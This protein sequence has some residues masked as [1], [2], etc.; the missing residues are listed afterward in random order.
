MKPSWPSYQMW[1]DL[2]EGV[3]DEEHEKLPYLAR[4]IFCG[5]T[6]SAHFKVELQWKR[7]SNPIET[8]RKYDDWVCG[9]PLLKSPRDWRKFG[10]K[11]PVFIE[12][13]SLSALKPLRCRAAPA[14]WTLRWAPEYLYNYTTI[15][16]KVCGPARYGKGISSTDLSLKMQ[17]HR[18]ADE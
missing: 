4:L 6:T 11:I 9:Q 12:I 5:W 10:L 17:P 14:F 8:Y 7:R 2:V 13:I 18:F 1:P 16:I 15:N 3:E